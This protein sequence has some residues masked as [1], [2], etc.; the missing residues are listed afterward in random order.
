[1]FDFACENVRLRYANKAIF[2]LRPV[3]DYDSSYLKIVNLKY[4]DYLE[5]KKNVHEDI[6]SYAT[7]S[8][9]KR[10]PRL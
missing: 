3:V 2:N 4:A 10:S 5:S 7:K 1:M 6:L 8:I 9:K